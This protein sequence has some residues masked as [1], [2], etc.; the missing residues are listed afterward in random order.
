[1][2]P[3]GERG[4]ALE[5]LAGEALG[6]QRYG[7]HG[8]IEPESIGQ[9]ASLGCIRLFNEDVE[10]LYTYLVEKHSTVIIR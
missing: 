1:M 6:Q 10:E 4:I 9:E 8:T 5:G 7:I 3:L 2:N